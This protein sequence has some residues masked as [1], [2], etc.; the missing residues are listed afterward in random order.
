MINVMPI[1]LIATMTVCDKV[2]RMLDGERYFLRAA[3]ENRERDDYQD[4]TD[5]RPK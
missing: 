4:Q 5:E 3:R 1:A 2:I